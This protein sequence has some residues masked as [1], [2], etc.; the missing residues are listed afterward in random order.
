MCEPHYSIIM[1]HFAIH[2]Y[3]TI[4][5]ALRIAIHLC[6]GEVGAHNGALAPRGWSLALHTHVLTLHRQAYCRLVRE[7]PL[8]WYHCYQSSCQSE[9]LFPGPPHLRHV[10]YYWLCLADH[11]HLSVL[12]CSTHIQP[13]EKAGPAEPTDSQKPLWEHLWITFNYNNVLMMF[14][15]ILVTVSVCSGSAVSPQYIIIEFKTNTLM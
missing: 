4:S 2:L 8:S 5:A 13:P 6:E 10:N 1:L 9:L 3:E 14:E 12:A 11:Y 15:P 7:L